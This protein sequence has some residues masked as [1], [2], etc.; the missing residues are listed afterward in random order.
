MVL[1][2]RAA[3]RIRMNTDPWNLTIA[4]SGAGR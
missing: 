4:P 2:R 3:E 1:A